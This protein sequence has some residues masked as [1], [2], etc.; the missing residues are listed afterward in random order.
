MAD[1]KYFVILLDNIDGR[2]DAFIECDNEDQMMHCFEQFCQCGDG[3]GKSTVIKGIRA[4]TIPEGI[5]DEEYPFVPFKEF[6]DDEDDD[7]EAKE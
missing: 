1:E 6:F 7:E 3:P 5:E 2:P 4:E